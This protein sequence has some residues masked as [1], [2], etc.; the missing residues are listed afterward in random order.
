MSFFEKF[1]TKVKIFF[2]RSLKSD[3]VFGNCMLKIFSI[4]H[5]YRDVIIFIFLWQN[6]LEPILN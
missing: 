1:L 4:P 5:G 6:L 2:Y 3:A